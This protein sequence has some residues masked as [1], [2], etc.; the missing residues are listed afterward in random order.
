MSNDGII[1]LN[2]DG[3]LNGYTKPIEIISNILRKPR[4]AKLD[5]FI[6]NHYD[7]CGV[8]VIKV[9][10]LKL[11]CYFTNSKVVISSACWRHEWYK[12]WD[13]K[14]PRIGKLHLW[15]ERF[16]I[17][18]I[19]ITELNES[20][21]KAIEKYCKL[22]RIQ[23]YVI[24][25]DERFRFTEEQMKHVVFTVDTSRLWKPDDYVGHKYTGMTM[26][27]VL[28]AIQILSKA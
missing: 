23:N 17:D 3:V 27:H 26:K 2:I 5:K 15:I 4:F 12:P 16:G 9:F 7:I 18:V 28:K 24:L 11:I 8:R 20:N 6:R 22:Y 10:Y 1:F 19:G 14:D 13:P 21:S 25:D